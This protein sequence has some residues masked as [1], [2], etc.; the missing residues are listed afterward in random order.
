MKKQFGFMTLA[1]GR[2]VGFLH[3]LVLKKAGYVWIP[4]GTTVRAAVQPGRGKWR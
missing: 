4:R 1:A 3:M 2:G